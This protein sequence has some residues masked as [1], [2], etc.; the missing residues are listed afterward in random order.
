MDGKMAMYEEESSMQIKDSW[1]YKRGVT[2]LAKSNRV[3]EEEPTKESGTIWRKAKLD[4]AS[5]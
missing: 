1:E 4:M 2:V 5:T 3:V